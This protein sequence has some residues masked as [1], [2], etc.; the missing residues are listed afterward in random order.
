[1]QNRAAGRS[2]RPDACMTRTRTILTIDNN[3]RPVDP[4]PMRASWYAPG[5]SDGLGD[6]LLMFDNAGGASLELL[7][8]RPEFSRA[9]LFEDASAQVSL[10]PPGRG[11]VG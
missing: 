10:K 5:L 8:F 9:P 2:Q 11:A 1:M 3:P 7:R 6:R 4:R